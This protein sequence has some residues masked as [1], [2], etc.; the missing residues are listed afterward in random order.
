MIHFLEYD[1]IN[2]EKRIDYYENF[3]VYSIWSI[4]AL[5]YRI[6]IRKLVGSAG[7]E[8][9]TSS[10]QGSKHTMLVDS[11]GVSSPRPLHYCVDV[12]YLKTLLAN[13]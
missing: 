12:Q 8:P 9:A 6:G 13:T 2:Y 4:L 7:F 5:C 3:T 11:F 10:A 1:G